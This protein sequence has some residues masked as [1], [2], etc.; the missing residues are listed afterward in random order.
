MSLQSL[1][2]I[3][4]VIVI[5]TLIEQGEIASNIPTC[6]AFGPAWMGHERGTLKTGGQ[7][8]VQEVP[9]PQ[10]SQGNGHPI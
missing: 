9:K 10:R 7:P 1:P 4:K 3:Y 8:K 5:V 2:A 6:D